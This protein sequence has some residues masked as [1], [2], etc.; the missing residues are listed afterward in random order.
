[1]STTMSPSHDDHQFDGSLLYA[2]HAYPRDAV[3]GLY[4]LPDGWPALP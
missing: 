4:R 3:R 1:M 2:L